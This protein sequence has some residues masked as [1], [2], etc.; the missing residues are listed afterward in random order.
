MSLKLPLLLFFLPCSN[1]TALNLIC[2]SSGVLVYIFSIF[3]VNIFFKFITLVSVWG[4][5]IVL[6]ICCIFLVIEIFCKV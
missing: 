4:S 1:A 3:L 6:Q 5:L 2:N